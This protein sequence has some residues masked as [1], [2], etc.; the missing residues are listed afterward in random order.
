MFSAS[1]APRAGRCPTLSAYVLEGRRLDLAPLTCRAEGDPQAAGRPAHG[2]L[3]GLTYV[4]SRRLGAVAFRLRWADTSVIQPISVNVLPAR[5]SATL[6]PPACSRGVCRVRYALRPLADGAQ[7]TLAVQR[8]VCS[9]WVPART[10][11]LPQQGRTRRVALAPGSY[12]MRV[13]VS[14]AAP[15]RGVSSPWRAATAG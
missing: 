2:R 1:P 7:A 4:A 15:Q 8:R 13:V 3:D 12:R 10:I 5:V 11:V 9:R 14:V 6:A